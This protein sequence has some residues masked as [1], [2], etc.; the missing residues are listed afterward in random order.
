MG[1]K[2]IVINICFVAD[3]DTRVVLKDGDLEVKGSDYICATYIQVIH[4]CIYQVD[5]LDFLLFLYVSLQITSETARAD[6]GQLIATQGCLSETV[7]D[8]WRM[9]WQE[10]SQ[11]I[12]M[13]TK[14]VEDDRVSVYS[15]VK[16]EMSL[17]YVKISVYRITRKLLNKYLWSLS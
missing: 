1:N 3:D 5:Q 8:F 12:V 17:T 16:I 10:R 9:V 2:I 4:G 11:V 14:A 7:G 6:R 13:A 15:F